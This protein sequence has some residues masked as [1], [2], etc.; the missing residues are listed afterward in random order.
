MSNF[1][2]QYEENKIQE[3]KPQSNNLLSNRQA[4][5]VQAAMIMA[6]RFP[7]DTVQAYSNIMN[8]CKRPSL[9][10]Q[11]E[12]TFPRGNQKITGP[13]IR[14]A[15]AIAQNWGN[16]DCGVIEL[17]Q[18]NNKSEMFA[19]AWDLE[20]NTRISKTFTV[21]HT[22]DTRQGSKKLTDMR[23][24]YEMTANMGAR[25]LRACILGIIPG[26]VVEKAV[27]QCR[28]TL[29]GNYTEPLQDRLIK[30]FEY[31]QDKFGVNREQIEEY[32][33]Y[34]SESFNE[35]DFIK[36]KGVVSSIKDGMSCVEDYFSK[37]TLNPFDKKEEEKEDDKSK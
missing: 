20:T 23:D 30:L 7:R 19:F 8:T 14:L 24:I 1:I 10:E 32:L 22:R 21:P 16:I 2:Q 18:N 31:F 26:D 37:K 15:E 11:A 28:N 25:R 3:I 35:N 17:S 6:K 13:S 27:E 29:K 33:G 12:Y 36:L 4:Q 34:K 5:E 9:A